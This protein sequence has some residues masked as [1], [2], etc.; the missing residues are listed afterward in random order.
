ML[1]RSIALAAVLLVPAAAQEQEEAPA[2]ALPR[3]TVESLQA[4]YRAAL[5]ELRAADVAHLDP[6]RQSRR[7]AVLDAL[8]AYLE[9]ADF[10]RSQEPDRVNLFRDGE[11]RRCAVAEV[12]HVTGADTLVERIAA[13][14]NRAFVLELTDVPGVAEWLDAVGLTAAEAAR[15]QAGCCGPPMG[16]QSDPPPPPPTPGNPPKPPTSGPSGAPTSGGPGSRATSGGARPPT[17]GGMPPGVRPTSGTGTGL[18]RCRGSGPEQFTAVEE[19]EP[20]WIWWELHR[21]ELL[22]PSRVAARDGQAFRQVSR[23]AQGAELARVD[24]DR[25]AAALG[26]RLRERLGD[27]DAQVRA[28]AAV[29]F[30]RLSG[31]P[32]LEDILPLLDDPSPAV[33]EAALLALGAT[34]GLQAAHTLLAVAQDGTR[35]GRSV[36]PM[37]QPLALLALGVARRRGAPDL[38]DDFLAQIATESRG[39]ERE[40]REAALMALDLAR[41]PLAAEGATGILAATRIERAD[42]P[43]AC[44]ALEALGHG[45]D[46]VRVP[47]LLHRAGSRDL[48]QRRAAAMALGAFRDPLLAG[49]LKTAFEVEEEPLARGFL[50]LAI[51]AQGR[52]ASGD[53]LLTAMSDGPSL[54]RPWAA[55]ALGLQAREQADADLAAALREGLQGASADERGAWLLAC[56]LARDVHAVPELARELSGAADPRVRMFAALGLGLSQ[57]PEAGDLLAARLGV[58]QS[59]TAVAGVVRALGALGRPQD[60]EPLLAELRSQSSPVLAAE[61][62]SALGW[63]GSLAAAEGLAAL[64][65][66]PQASSLARAAGL[67]ALGL[68]LDVGEPLL[69]AQAVRG[70]NFA[71]LPSWFLEVLSTTTL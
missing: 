19:L 54:A 3:I 13:E 38:V 65:D 20:W 41:S 60:V 63:H 59:P 47:E 40:V 31:A 64:V 39:D 52:Q 56:G 51:G 16:P 66:D 9:R 2:G 4:H 1:H 32:A 5:A 6:D 30:G 27:G 24:R 8:Q 46:P 35:D 43:L 68:A 36:S 14:R 61:V 70:R 29:T 48:Q 28:A 44:R 18:L 53:F 34:G 10:G 26:P 58:E 25:L 55:L 50:L 11:G 69:L 49:P 71:A 15:V 22:P 62:A 42:A 67:D 37:A 57:A 23:Y 7:C 45:G 12:M 33:R 17:T 21:S